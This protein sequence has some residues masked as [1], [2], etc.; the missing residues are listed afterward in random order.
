MLQLNLENKPIL[1]ISLVR[2]SHSLFIH[3]GIL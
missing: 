3:Y 1:G 2:L